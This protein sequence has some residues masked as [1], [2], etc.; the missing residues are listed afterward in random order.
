MGQPADMATAQAL[1]LAC[2]MDLGFQV[3]DKCWAVCYDSRLSREELVSGQWPDAKFTAM[4]KCGNKCI[5]R[6]FE[7]MQHMIEGR[8]K[9]EREQ[10]GMPP[11]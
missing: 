10:A 1:D 7:V 4:S 8:Q 6:Y 9:R 11:E 2:R 5:A 3:V